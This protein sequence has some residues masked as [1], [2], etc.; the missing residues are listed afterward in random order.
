VKFKDIDIGK[1]NKN[2]NLRSD[3]KTFGM[4]SERIFLN[5]A[6]VQEQKNLKII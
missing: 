3:H 5:V 2:V 6:S 1:G 4:V